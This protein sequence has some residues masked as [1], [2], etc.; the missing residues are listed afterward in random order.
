MEARTVSSRVAA[1]LEKNV[2]RFQSSFV[3]ACCAALIA[4]LAITS[5]TGGSSSATTGSTLPSWL[6]HV[7][8]VIQENRSF[9]DLF[10]TFPGADGAVLASSST[11][12]TSS[13]VS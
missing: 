13:A 9:D 12:N 2:R 6:S 1:L 11:S 4:T 3:R 5:C 8:V 10:A 7:V